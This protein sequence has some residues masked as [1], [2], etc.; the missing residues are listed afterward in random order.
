MKILPTYRINIQGDAKN[1]LAEIERASAAGDK[2]INKLANIPISGNLSSQIK[3]A[4]AAFRQ[5][6]QIQDKVSSKKIEILPAKTFKEAKFNADSFFKDYFRDQKRVE[7]ESEK[8]SEKYKVDQ[9]NAIKAVRAKDAAIK[10]SAAEQDKIL[11]KS[12][13]E[14]NK[15]LNQKV[16]DLAASQKEREAL[17]KKNL[18]TRKKNA[19]AIIRE[20][21]SLIDKQAKVQASIIKETANRNFEKVA[22]LKQDRKNLQDEMK[23]SRKELAEYSDINGFDKETVSSILRNKINSDYESVIRNAKASV[24][25]SLRKKANAEMEKELARRK[26]TSEAKIKILE[27]EQKAEQA[28]IDREEIAE[29]NRLERIRDRERDSYYNPYRE[30]YQ[31]IGNKSDVQKKMSD[32]YSELEKSSAKEAEELQKSFDK[33]QEKFLYGDFES[34]MRDISR[35]RL[36]YKGQEAEE[37]SSLENMRKYADEYEA[38]Y[39]KIGKHFNSA[40]SFK[41]NDE[42]VVASFKNMEIAARRFDNEMKDVGKS[43]TKNLDPGVARD[44]ADK[45]KVFMA[46]NTKALKKYGN[47]LK[48]IEDRYYQAR[49]VGDK[50][51]V[52][53]EFNSVKANIRAEGLTGKTLMGTL[54]S[55]FKQIAEISGIYNLIQD[56]AFEVPQK[57]FN[58]VKDVNAAQIELTKVSDASDNQLTAYWDEA[59]ESAMKYGSTISDVIS[60]TADWSRLGYNLEESKELSNATTLLQ[61]IGD[62]MTQESASEG[63]ISTLKGFSLEADEVM[64]VVD[65]VN[66]VNIAASICSNVY[67]LCA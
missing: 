52:D 55:R 12:E 30:A 65:K 20:E 33:Y 66:E 4:D 46:E 10:K 36:A 34:K 41:M 45:V 14:Q 59:A 53:K 17:D 3:N 13:A 57:M 67:A 48:D 19:E 5:I 22:A 11:K 8:I 23:A 25:D 50:I 35:K 21:L 62:N 43:M 47:A 28:R 16:K 37:D 29:R 39:E 56:F 49:S 6:G 2:L 7:E 9:K 42:E 40:D 60:N 24:S 54:S 32:Y 31:S 64:S 27:Q 44:S 26:R 63:L 15:I 51:A 58:A 38:E 1:L 18:A 61:K